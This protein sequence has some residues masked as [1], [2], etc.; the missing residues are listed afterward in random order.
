MTPQEIEVVIQEFCRR[1]PHACAPRPAAQN[2]GGIALR[3]VKRL[4]KVIDRL[5]SAAPCCPPLI[6]PWASLSLDGG[7][8][9][10]IPDPGGDPSLL[11]FEGKSELA[12]VLDGTSIPNSFTVTLRVHDMDDPATIGLVSLVPTTVAGMAA[13]TASITNAVLTPGATWDQLAIT[14]DTSNA[15]GDTYGVLVLQNAC[16]CQAAIGVAIT[17]AA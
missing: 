14:V 2:G 17:A 8:A 16:G 13:I 12:V 15:A 6:S 7:G 9:N 5:K 4:K 1:F 3:E 10:P 11:P